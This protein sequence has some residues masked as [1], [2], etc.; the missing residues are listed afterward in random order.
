[1]FALAT[2]L[3]GDGLWGCESGRSSTRD[4]FGKTRRDEDIA[5]VAPSEPA[6]TSVE[7]FVA[8]TAALLDRAASAGVNA[9]RALLTLISSRCRI[10]SSGK[11]WRRCPFAESGLRL[12]DMLLLL[13]AD[14]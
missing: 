5:G 10:E 2:D 8:T 7:E 12:A 3:M 13:S 11:T 9:C 4:R 6:P 1:M 14:C